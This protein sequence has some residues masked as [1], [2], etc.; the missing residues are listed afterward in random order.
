MSKI[1]S[2]HSFRGGTG[3][4][5]STANLAAILAMKGY[6]VGV[7]DTDVNSPGIH[8]I[9][10]LEEGDMVHTLNDYLWGKCEIQ[11][12]AQDVT[13][14]LGV[15]I[16]GQVFLIPS[17]TKATL[18]LLMRSDGAKSTSVL[19][20]IIIFTGFWKNRESHFLLG[21]I[22]F[23]EAVLDHWLWFLA[24]ESLNHLGIS[25]VQSV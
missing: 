14:N 17:S 1:V 19:S 20:T 3:K 24:P 4:S 8:V 5:N 15:D 7:V 16:S 10:N 13:A 2:I 18:L 9:F 6:R 21:I 25:K 11:D 12:A 22:T 23:Q